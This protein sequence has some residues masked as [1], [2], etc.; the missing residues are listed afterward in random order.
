MSG[1]QCNHCAFRELQRSAKE[2]GERLVTRR[3]A[4]RLGGINVY[5]VKK[6]AHQPQIMSRTWHDAHFHSWYMELTSHCVC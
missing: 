5:C 1:R 2:R 3:D 6:G 4:G